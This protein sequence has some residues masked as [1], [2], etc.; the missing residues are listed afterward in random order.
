LYRV[1]ATWHS[2]ATSRYHYQSRAAALAKI[3]RLRG[4]PHVKE[5]VM[6][7]SEPIRF[8]EEEA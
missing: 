3:L 1:T 8:K 5:T 7:A 6:H 4:N 2:G